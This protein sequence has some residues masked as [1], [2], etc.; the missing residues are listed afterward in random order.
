M[1][2]FDHS[3]DAENGEVTITS[4][5]AA[6]IDPNELR[7]VTRSE[8]RAFGDLPWGDAHD[9][10]EAGD[11]ITIDVSEESNVVVVVHDVWGTYVELPLDGDDGD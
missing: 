11:S 6:S 5:T 8:D 1:L 9:S 2:S 7:V 4:R 3:Y 10:V